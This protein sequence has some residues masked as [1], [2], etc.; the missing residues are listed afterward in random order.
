MANNDQS[1]RDRTRLSQP[2]DDPYINWLKALRDWYAKQAELWLRVFRICQILTITSS[3]ITVVIGAISTAS[4][5][6]WSKWVIVGASAL[7]ALSAAISSEFRVRQM[8]ALR[9]EG[10]AEAADLLA[11]ARDKLAE[12]ADNPAERFKLK[13]VIRSRLT[14]LEKQQG[15][16]FSEL[17]HRE[18]KDRE[19]SIPRQ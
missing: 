16:I 2:A 3:V 13:D 1:S 10:R 7:G 14:E 8:I 15:R 5:I 9:E 18:P 11:L 19:S 12:H 4:N 6:G 17:H